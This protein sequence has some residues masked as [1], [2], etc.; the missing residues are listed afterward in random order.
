VHYFATGMSV[1]R[2]TNRTAL[3]MFAFIIYK[4]HATALLLYGRGPI[5]ERRGACNKWRPLVIVLM[6]SR[7]A[8]ILRTTCMWRHGDH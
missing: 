8:A 3:Q 7:C 1:R 5:C 2:Q 4:C 6:C